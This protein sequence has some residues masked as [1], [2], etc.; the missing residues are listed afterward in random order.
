MGKSA[1]L[2]IRVPLL[3]KEQLARGAAKKDWT[4][5]H[6]VV[7]LLQGAVGGKRKK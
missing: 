3:L 4:V 7:R 6:Y 1:V 5:S 2:S